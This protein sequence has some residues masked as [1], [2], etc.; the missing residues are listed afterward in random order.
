MNNTKGELSG[1]GLLRCVRRGYKFAKEQT[2]HIF[3]ANQTSAAKRLSSKFVYEVAAAIHQEFFAAHC[4]NVISVD[5]S[6]ERDSGEWLVDACI[7]KKTDGFIDEIVF[8]MESESSQAGAAFNE[9]FAKL[10]HL[11]AAFKLY[12]SG[13]SHKTELGMEMHIPERIEECKNIL[14]R[15]QQNGR[16]FVAFWPSP[17]KRGKL[18]SAWLNL[19]SW[20]DQIRMWEFDGGDPREISR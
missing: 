7:T 17:A 1:E 20:L 15:V 10:L 13:L 4:L 18:E 2:D 9:D 19:P 12:L 14:S 16:L 5:N 6:G 3:D 8:A 11:N